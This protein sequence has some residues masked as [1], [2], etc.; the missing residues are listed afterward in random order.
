M[1]AAINSYIDGNKIGWLVNKLIYFIEDFILSKVLG[2]PLDTPL[3]TWS[4][5]KGFLF[6]FSIDLSCIFT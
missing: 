6:L 4:I 1:H 5:K 2:P 3:N